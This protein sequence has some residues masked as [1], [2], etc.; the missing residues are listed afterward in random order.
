MA[1]IRAIEA[2]LAALHPEGPALVEELKRL[3]LEELI[4]LGD[5]ADREL[6]RLW[7]RIPDGRRVH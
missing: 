6:T 2:R 4:V 7:A 3:H 5:E 1:R